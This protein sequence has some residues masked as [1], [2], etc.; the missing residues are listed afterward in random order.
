MFRKKSI[1]ASKSVKNNSLMHRNKKKLPFKNPTLIDQAKSKSSRADPIPIFSIQR[2]PIMMKIAP[3]P[4]NTDEDKP[5]IYIFFLITRCII[6]YCIGE[7]IKNVYCQISRVQTRAF[8]PVSTI[9]HLQ[10]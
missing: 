3:S 6:F 4:C 8:Y 10:V 2:V 1:T 7:D 5:E 9:K